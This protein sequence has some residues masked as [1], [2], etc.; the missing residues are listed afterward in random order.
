MPDQIEHII[1]HE[2]VVFIHADMVKPGW[3][4]S[5]KD[6]AELKENVQIVIHNAA[7][8]RLGD[9]LPP[10]IRDNTLGALDLAEM[11]SKFPKLERFVQITS[12]LINGFLPDG[13]VEEKIYPLSDFNTPIGDPEGELNEILA[14]GATKFLPQFPWPYAYSKHLVERLLITRY[15]NMPLLIVRPSI[16]GPAI[17][18]PYP[19]YGPDGSNPVDVLMQRLMLPSRTGIETWH[20]REGRIDGSNHL[21]DVPCDLIANILLI[22]IALETD[23]I[24]HATC[25]DPSVYP[26]RSIGDLVRLVTENAPKDWLSWM[27][28]NVFTPDHSTEQGPYAKFYAIG[29]SEWKYSHA[30]SQGPEFFTGPLSL[31]I[32]D[33]DVDE[34]RIKRVKIAV[35]RVKILIEDMK[36]RGRW[37][38][39][40]HRRQRL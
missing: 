28:V 20:Q 17:K 16:I 35:E 7:N 2:N 30:R 5:A 10:V 24:V 11:S 34:F 27:P 18:E 6:L 14:T 12:A 33:H 29:G 37:N 31:D 32:G 15:P 21:D 25:A 9:P 13:F 1:K 26:T 8:I 36:K 39:R 19:C 22:H 3:G 38:P 40:N 23:G 4:I